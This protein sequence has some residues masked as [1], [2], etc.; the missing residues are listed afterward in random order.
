M[1]FSWLSES[2]LK[3]CPKVILYLLLMF[4][5]PCSKR[6]DVILKALAQKTIS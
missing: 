6:E 4:A 2:R 3:Y 1:I 5:A